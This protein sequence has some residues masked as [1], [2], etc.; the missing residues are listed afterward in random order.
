MSRADIINGLMGKPYRLGGQGGDDAV[1]CYSATRHLQLALFGR[2][3][4][5]F[6]MPSEAGRLAIAAAIAE[7][8]ERGRWIEIAKP[9]DGAIVTMARNVCGYHLG[10]WLA[11]DGGIIVHALEEVGVVADTL[12]SLA[13]IGWRR[14]RFHVPA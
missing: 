3:M 4:P 10:T 8:P 12:P 5:A 6:D 9:R 14:F 2:D 13:S 7:H 11:E 1:D